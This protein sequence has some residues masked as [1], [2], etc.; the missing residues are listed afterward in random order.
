MGQVYLIPDGYWARYGIRF[1]IFR[2]YGSGMGLGDTRTD[3]PKL[4]TRLPELYTRSYTR[5]FKF[6]LF[7]INRFLLVF[8][9]M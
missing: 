4:H 5:I 3:Y 7:S 2:G 8:L 9:L 1:K 6:F